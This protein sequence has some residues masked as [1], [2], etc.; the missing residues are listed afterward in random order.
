MYSPSSLSWDEL[1]QTAKV[2]ADEFR[3]RHLA[4]DPRA[5][6]VLDA[7]VQLAGGIDGPRGMAMARYKNRQCCAAVVVEV[8]VSDAAEVLVRRAW[9]AADAG[10]VV[11]RDGLV[12]QLEGG[13]VQA[14]SWTL[15]EEVS[16]D[17]H[18]V[19][20]SDWEDYPILRFSDVPPIETTLLDH[21]AQPPVGAGEALHGPASAAVANAIF[22]ATGI[23]PRHLPFTPAN[24]RRA[25]A[26]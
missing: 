26:G 2:P 20:D 9:I 18:G 24:L 13:F 19:I 6:A 10:R 22:A 14:L 3:R 21:P 1:A 7:A 23:R 25:A 4:H 12:N 5:L 8:A 11:D 16:F 15:F 17:T